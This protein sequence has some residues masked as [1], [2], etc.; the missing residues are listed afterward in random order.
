MN[1]LFLSMKR[2]GQHGVINWF[3]QQ[4]NH[5]SAH[6]NNCCNGWHQK[7]LVPMKPDMIVYYKFH[8]NN[9]RVYDLFWGDSV[10]STGENQFTLP[11]RFNMSKKEFMLKEIGSVSDFLYNV[12]D[13]TISQYKKHRIG[14]FRQ[15]K[16]DR[17]I[18]IILRDPYN[19]IASCLQRTIKDNPK[20][21]V[22]INLSERLIGWKEHAD[23]ILNQNK[24]SEKTYF[25][26]YNEWF[27]SEVYR[28]QICD[29]LSLAF[30]DNGLNQVT[31][32]GKGSSF[33]YQ[34]HN[35]SAQE[36]KVLERYKTWQHN[37]RFKSFIDDEIEYYAKEIF[38]MK[39]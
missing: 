29:D 37:D 12:E 27:R 17:K 6:Y 15:I 36:M 24:L 35:G 32:F 8:H 38:G 21:D 20:A 39:I 9:H 14:E 25:I 19:F 28:K 26:N 23:Q 16:K 30:T 13:L 31:T 1:Y 22:A 2:S 10:W 18:I 34:N 33:D 5:N 3:A 11:R 7:K 4:N